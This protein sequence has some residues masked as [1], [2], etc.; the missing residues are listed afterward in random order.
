[1]DMVYSLVVLG[2]GVAAVILLSRLGSAPRRIAPLAPVLASP[3][4]PVSVVIPTLN[5]AQR[6]PLCLAGLQN[7]PVAEIVVVDSRST[8]GTPE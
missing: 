5:E 1:M 3:P 8:D 7:Q 2:Q 4:L 6:L